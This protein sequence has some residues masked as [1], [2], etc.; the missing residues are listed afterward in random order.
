MQ[1]LFFLYFFACVVMY[2]DLLRMAY[3]EDLATTS[4]E[5]KGFPVHLLD[6]LQAVAEERALSL[7]GLCVEILRNHAAE[8]EGLS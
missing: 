4:V 6:V 2:A 1:F 5:I 3:M 7:D 8:M